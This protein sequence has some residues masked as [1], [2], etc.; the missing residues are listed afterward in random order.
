MS[1]EAP[2]RL[3]IIGVA[4]S[5][6]S[7]LARRLGECLGARVV[8]LDNVAATDG[9]T[10]LSEPY[11]PFGEQ[12]LGEFVPRVL[13]ERLAIVADIAASPAWIVEGAFL[14]W[15]GDLMARADR[16]VWLDQVG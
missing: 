11:A 9:A 16:I 12:P 2:H 5:G 4:G 13:D 6:K 3:L 10:D 8:H 1:D 15:L 14:D 7:S